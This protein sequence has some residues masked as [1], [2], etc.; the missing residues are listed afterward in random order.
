MWKN[1]VKV[2]KEHKKVLGVKTIK[3]DHLKL[4]SIE[5]SLEGRGAYLDLDD[6][7]ITQLCI[8]IE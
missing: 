1:P 5:V 7:P 4:I 6:V 2:Y 3:L 8:H